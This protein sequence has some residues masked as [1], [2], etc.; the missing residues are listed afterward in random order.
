MKVVDL[1]ENQDGSA[2]ANVDLTQ[3]EAQLLMQV[4]FVKLLEDAI[5]ADKQRRREPALFRKGE[6]YGGSDE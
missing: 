6:S 1:I 4:G 3:E 5:K 2:T